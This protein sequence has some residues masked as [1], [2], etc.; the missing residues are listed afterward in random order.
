MAF[1]DAH[2]G[3]PERHRGCGLG[4]LGVG[5]AATGKPQGLTLKTPQ[6]KKASAKTRKT[7]LEQDALPLAAPLSSDKGQCHEHRHVIQ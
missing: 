7:Y 2:S 6:K 5:G 1:A 4:A 3:R